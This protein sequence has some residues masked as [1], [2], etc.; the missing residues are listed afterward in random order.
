MPD[1]VALIGVGAMGQ[2][3]LSRLRAA[4]NEVRAYDVSPAALQAA[5]DG[6]AT[7]AVSPADAARGAAYVHVIVASDEQT[8]QVTLG[9][10]GVS[11]EAAPGTLVFLHG[12]ILPA[13]T[14]RIAEAAAKNA[15]DVLDA[16]IAAVPKR[17]EKGEAAF[18]VGGP[19]A[20]VEKARGYL[21]QLGEAVHHFGPLGAGNVAKLARALINAGERVLLAEVLAILEAAGIDLRQFLEIERAA[22]RPSTLALW[23]KNFVIEH[24][25]ARHRLAT[26]LFNK[27]VM[28]AAEL[29]QLYGVDAPLS[30]GAAR[31]A[32][33]W[34]QEWAKLPK[35]DK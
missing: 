4:G 33:R 21:M 17:L 2:A 1:R 10:D 16:P 28:L 20:L 8:M 7:V 5:R 32:A 35:R 25:H 14:Q 12:T 34:V 13:T 30:Q 3:L 27:D 29:S 11:A 22:D 6:G 9:P 24:G 31:T 18:L 15:V 26:N 23:D 19:P